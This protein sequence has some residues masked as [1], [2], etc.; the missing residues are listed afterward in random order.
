MCGSELKLT[1]YILHSCDNRYVFVT[2][3]GRFHLTL[4]CTISV[5][6]TKTYGKFGFPILTEALSI[7]NVIGKQVRITA[8]NWYGWGA[9]YCS[10]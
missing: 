6:K 7:K 2:F 5:L 4:P 1:L 9:G 10:L 3:S 8:D